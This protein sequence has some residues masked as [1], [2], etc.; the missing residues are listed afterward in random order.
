MCVVVVVVSL[1]VCT[2]RPLIL[3]VRITIA[4]SYCCLLKDAGGHV[5]LVK[6][7]HHLEIYKGSIFPKRRKRRRRRRKEKKKKVGG[8]GGGG[9]G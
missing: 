7:I 6:Q 9:E 5:A 1:I 2:G 8:G 3:L 4:L